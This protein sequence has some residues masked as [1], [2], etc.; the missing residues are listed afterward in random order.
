MC[1][2]KLIHIFTPRKVANLQQKAKDEDSSTTQQNYKA[3]S[4]K[5]SIW[6]MSQKV[7]SWWQYINILTIFYALN[8]LHNVLKLKHI[9][10]GS[11]LDHKKRNYKYQISLS[12]VK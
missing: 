4:F 8:Q 7:K 10:Q 9:K 2:H 1:A 5:N 11:A 12:V 3:A 6:E